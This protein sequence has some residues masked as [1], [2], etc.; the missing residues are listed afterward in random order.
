MM[1][2]LNYR[3]AQ[4]LREVVETGKLPL[5]DPW[6]GPPIPE[7]LA[8]LSALVSEGFLLDDQ[9]TQKGMLALVDFSIREHRSDENAH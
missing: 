2:D 3:E 1:R 7:Y 9:V 4:I 6:P 8:D 5:R